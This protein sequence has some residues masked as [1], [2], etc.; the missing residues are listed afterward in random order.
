MIFI[1]IARWRAEQVNLQL[2][3]IMGIESPVAITMVGLTLI[4]IAGR[5][6]DSNVVLTEQWELLVLLGALTILAAMSLVGRKDLGLRIPSALEGIVLLILTSKLLTSLMGVD[7]IQ[8][9][10]NLSSESSWVLPVWSL[11]VFLVSAVL[12]FEWVE[13]ERIKRGLGDHRG[14]AGRFAWAAM[15]IAISFGIAGIIASIFAL[16]NSIK[17]IQPAVPVGI[18]IFLPISW[19]A[20]GNWID[21]L[22]ETTGIFMIFVGTIGLAVAIICTVKKNQ[23]WIPAGLWIGHLLIPS[24][25]FG[26]YQQTSVLMMVLMLAVSTTSW[27]IGVI[28]LRR[29]W[30]IFGAL[31]LLLAWIIAGVLILAGATELMVLIM[32]LA[33]AILLGLVTWLGQKYE[34]QIS[35]T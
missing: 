10:P 2:P 26:H 20:L 27:L 19:N 11:E 14:A 33:T 4:Q 28:T 16:R 3:D 22:N 8:F 31:D 34:E 29:A 25:A 1:G 12:L 7:T 35:V 21:L 15:I 32:L 23:V 18:G 17:W 6:G 5:L 9:V 13:S 30:R 24:G